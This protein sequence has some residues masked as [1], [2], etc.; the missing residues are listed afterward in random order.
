IYYCL[1]KEE[2]EEQEAAKNK[3]TTRDIHGNSPLSPQYTAAVAGHMT[4]QSHVLEGRMEWT[5]NVRHDRGITEWICVHG[6]GHPDLN[7]LPPG[8]KGIHGCCGCCSRSDFPGKLQRKAQPA[9][10]T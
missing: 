1:L 3:P 8:D 7:T 10:F 6:V 2:R 9:V 4:D 5:K